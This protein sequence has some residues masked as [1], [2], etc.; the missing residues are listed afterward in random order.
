MIFPT[1]HFCNPDQAPAGEKSCGVAYDPRLQ[2]TD[3]PTVLSGGHPA[4]VGL[5][6]SAT[7][8]A[9]LWSSIPFQRNAAVHM[10]TTGLGF[11]GLLAL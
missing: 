10:A 4:C 3:C 9:A 1:V 11:D 2:P 5:G 8:Q 7:P 6:Q